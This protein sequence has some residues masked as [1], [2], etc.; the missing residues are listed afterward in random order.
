MPKFTKEQQLAIDL[1]GQNILVSAG[2]GSGKTAVLSERV[3]RKVKSGVSVDNLLVLTFT[4]AAAAEMKERIRDKILK[5][6]LLEEAEKVESSYITTFDSFTL[7][8]V[9]K[10]HYKK[11]LSKKI[12]VVDSGI[13]TLKKKQILD[14]IFEDLYKNKDEKFLDLISNFSFKNDDDIYNFIKKSQKEIDLIYYKNDFFENYLELKYSDDYINKLLDKYTSIILK[15]IKRSS[16]LFDELMRADSDYASNYITLIE[17]LFQSNTYDEV[18]NNFYD[19]FKMVRN[20]G[21]E[22]KAIKGALSESL[23][24]IKSY[25]KYESLNDFKNEYLNTKKYVSILLDIIKKYDDEIY[26]FKL[27]NNMFEFLDIEKLAIDI[28]SENE[29]VRNFYKNKFNEILID[30]YQDTSDIQEIFVNLISNNNVYMVGDIKQSI[31]R[32]RNANP[33]IF[34]DKFNNYGINNGGI[35]ID[36]NKNFRSREEVLSNINLIF[37]YLMDDNIGGANY[38]KEHQLSFGNNTYNEAGY[39]G[40][41]NNFEVLNYELDESKKY[42]NEEIE[43]FTMVKDIKEKI[44]NKYMIFDKDTGQKRCI[45]Y[46]DIAILID[47]SKNFELIKKIFTY[48]NIP[49]ITFSDESIKESININI[50]KNFLI[51]VSSVHAKR[52]DKDFLYALASILRSYIYEFTDEEI[53]SILENKDFYKTDLFNKIKDIIEDFED[54]TIYDFVILLIEKFNIYENLIKIGNIVE[55]TAVIDYII[56]LSKNASSLFLLDEFINYLDNVTYGDIEIKFS[57]PQSDNDAV[58]L[59]TIHKSKGLEYPIVYFPFLKSKFNDLDIKAKFVFDQKLGFILPDKK[60][61][62][63]NTSFL[64]ILMKDDFKYA[65]ISERLRLFYVA[66]TRAKEKFIFIMNFENKKDYVLNGVLINDYDRLKYN[67][68]KSVL[69]SVNKV[70]YDFTKNIN[71]N[72]LSMHKDYNFV[73]KTNY[74]NLIPKEGSLVVI[75]KENTFVIENQK[76]FSK[77]TKTLFNNSE[78]ENI[79]LG[80]KYHKIFESIDFKNISEFKCPEE[81]KNVVDKFLSNSILNDA[82]EFYKEYEFVYEK[83]NDLMHGIVDLLIEKENEFI[84]VDYK[85]NNIADENYVKQLNGYKNYIENISNKKTSI[86]LYSLLQGKLQEL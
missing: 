17:P 85:L 16:E 81:Y 45:A 30:E 72:D 23:K 26:N 49:L 1:E 4:N 68:F 58:K 3:L 73:K 46:S 42:S 29:D 44:N 57:I 6:G 9:K 48:E 75:E 66:L 59:M 76:S 84:I 27:K 61:N 31:Y 33:D 55:N 65:D 24:T 60:E 10:Y 32:F 19:E 52:Y 21:E 67:S 79:A 62:I 47:K 8:V 82:I 40:Q 74:E 69:E 80:L 41:N 70:I 37:N 12:S 5:E 64:K 54:K 7:S 20:R 78:K 15:E 71:V 13:I 28:I 25:L 38:E 14:S 53:H 2:A 11:N 18:I 77:K 86:Y 63:T 39:T 34:R 51:L 22:F 83:D 50:I 35:R 36:L 43:I 56:D